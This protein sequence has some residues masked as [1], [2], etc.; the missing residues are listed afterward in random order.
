LAI[1]TVMVPTILSI[2]LIRSE[3]S[4]FN[5]SSVSE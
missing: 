1:M 4:S 2:L 3:T 5:F